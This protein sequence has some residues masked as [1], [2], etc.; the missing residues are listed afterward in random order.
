MKFAC[1]FTRWS[2]EVWNVVLELE[3]TSIVLHL[4]Q[5]VEEPFAKHEEGADGVVVLTYH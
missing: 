4:L 3:G 5:L 1:D 2:T